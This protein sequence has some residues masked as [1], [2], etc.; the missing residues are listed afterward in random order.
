M[1]GCN[2]RDHIE[3]LVSRYRHCARKTIDLDGRR[4]W[5]RVADFRRSFNDSIALQ[6]AAGHAKMMSASHW[7]GPVS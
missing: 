7:G 5:Q 1:L 3:Y 2:F 6:I 4:L